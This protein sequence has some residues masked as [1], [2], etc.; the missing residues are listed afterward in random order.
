MK[1]MSRIVAVVFIQANLINVAP[2]QELPVVVQQQL[3]NVSEQQLEGG[4]DS[5]AQQLLQF[6][7]HPLQL[8]SVDREEL[9]E[10]GLLNELQI[11]SFLSYRRILGSVVH[12]YELQ[13]I[14][15]WDIPTIRRLLPYVTVA[16]SSPGKE[17]WHKRFK[18]G[19][20]GVTISISQTVDAPADDGTK[21]GYTGS[22]QRLYFRHRYN[23]KNLLQWGILGE[24]DAGESF[25]KGA[26]RT[27]F[28]FYSF[29]LFVRKAGIIHSFAVGD[30]TVNMGQGLFQ[31]QSMAFGK[32]G[33]AAAIRRQSPVLRPYGSAGEFN[34]QRG[35][36]VTLQRKKWMSTYFISLRKLS[37]SIMED[38]NGNKSFSSMQTSGYHRTAS[39]I[40][41]KNTIR[42]FGWGTNWQYNKGSLHA[43]IS[44]V[45][46][47]YSLPLKGSDESY[48]LFAIDG[49]VWYNAGIDYG[50]TFRNL[51][52]FGEASIDRYAHKAFLTGIL[53]SADRHV[54]ISLLYRSIPE[55]YQSVYGNAFTENT[56]PSNEKGLYG[57]IVVRPADRWRLDAYADI[58]RFPWL[59]YRV[60]A[61]GGGSDFLLQLTYS[62]NKFTQL[63][64]RFRN[65]SKQTNVSDETLTVRSPDFY[66]KQSCRIQIESKINANFSWRQR[67]EISTYKQDAVRENGFL[68][69]FDLI[70]KPVVKPFSCIARLQ[71]HETSGYNA[72]IYAYE[73]DVLYSY[74]IP[75][76]DGKGYRYYL[77]VSYDWKRNFSCW[78]RWA[79]TL[80]NGGAKSEWKVQVRYEF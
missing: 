19:E 54:D 17:E 10:L 55:R 38:S 58:Y 35:I 67:T 20:H 36:G 23:Y 60:D 29:H 50:Y 4:D 78:L 61:P 52:F 79:Q 32:S 2:S 45:A 33:D 16:A 9:E 18:D 39:E 65:E 8:N 48:K 42:Q 64:I 15:G 6:A 30:F 51:H 53:I 12:I 24:K 31:W 14:P 41:N 77:L 43:G 62:P 26:Q 68:G 49:N 56:M 3:E 40:R 28:D 13:A 74:S 7:K 63:M 72:R 70:Y 80:F 11:G 71:Y 22:P 69:A 1:R 59:K 66:Y 27:G 25:L 75:M 73:N 46:Y 76:F 57:G 34:F 5:F 37:A 47:H 44:Y 21:S